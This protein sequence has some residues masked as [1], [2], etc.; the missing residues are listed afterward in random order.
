[1]GESVSPSSSKSKQKKEMHKSDLFAKPEGKIVSL[2][3][4]YNGLYDAQKLRS[5]KLLSS[6]LKYGVR[7]FPQIKYAKD[8]IGIWVNNVKYYN[9]KAQEEVKISFFIKRQY[10]AGFACN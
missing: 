4:V 7:I 2:K 1:M 8:L 5:L 3:L 10:Y 6:V 9:K